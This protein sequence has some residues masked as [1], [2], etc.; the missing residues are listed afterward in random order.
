MLL[1]TYNLAFEFILELI[2]FILQA[3]VIKSKYNFQAEGVYYP[4][5]V[6]IC[7]YESQYFCICSYKFI[8]YIGLCNI[9]EKI[10]YNRL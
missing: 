5:V 10:F 8:L 4:H 2:Y 9:Y 3:Q 1:S 6:P 7:F